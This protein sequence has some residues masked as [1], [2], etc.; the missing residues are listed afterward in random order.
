MT[1]T[2]LTAP[3][4]RTSTQWIGH[5]AV[6]D[7]L[8]KL[9][10]E[11]RMPHALIFSGARGIGKATA[12]YHLARMAFAG[13]EDMVIPASHP[14]HQRIRAGS[15]ADLKV[16]QGGSAP[17]AKTSEIKIDEIRALNAFMPMTPSEGGWRVAILDG[18]ED[19]NPNAANALLKTLE[20]P[21]PHSLLILVC[22]N[23]GKLLPTIR[24]RCRQ[25]AF[26]PLSEQ[27]YQQVLLEIAPEIGREEAAN[28]GILARHS[29][30]VALEYDQLGALALYRSIIKLMATMPNANPADL[31][32]FATT[33]ANKQAHNNW[34]IFSELLL[35]FLSRLHMPNIP[36]AVEAEDVALQ[37][38]GRLKS[39][40]A[41]ADDW[42]RLRRNF[43]LAEGVH[44][45]YKS[46][47]LTILASLGNEALALPA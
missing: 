19:M 11:Q 24:S 41:W 1:D 5:Q 2:E 39:K 16:I 4:P 31:L 10:R 32:A 42:F 3:I 14:V 33:I 7:R 43:V 15:H 47:T 38:L 30:G 8:L 13:G 28:L 9:W 46:L 18:A 23:A 20:E 27:E 34:R 6:S 21:P 36:A 44:L 25:V 37:N 40:E 35:H 26:S 12:A 45:D 29:P 22:H 17:D